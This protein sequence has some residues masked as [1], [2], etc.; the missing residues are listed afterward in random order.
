MECPNCPR[1]LNE[2][3]NGFETHYQCPWCDHLETIPNPEPED[4]EEEIAVAPIRLMD[5]LTLSTKVVIF[6]LP[7]AAVIDGL[8]IYKIFFE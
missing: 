7:F 5:R 4:E 1:E 3:N 2:F 8:I 6:L